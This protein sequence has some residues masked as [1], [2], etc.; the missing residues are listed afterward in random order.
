MGF[1]E[2]EPAI[3]SLAA[4]RAL[5][6]PLRGHSIR[7][8]LNSPRPV[9]KLLKITLD[10]RLC[11]VMSVNICFSRIRGGCYWVRPGGNISFPIAWQ[12]HKLSK[13]FP[14]CSLTCTM[15]K[16]NEPLTAFCWSEAVWGFTPQE[17]RK[18]CWVRQTLPQLP[19][20]HMEPVEFPGNTL[21]QQFVSHKVFTVWSE[22]LEQIV[23][24]IDK[25]NY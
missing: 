5:K 1:W 15:P 22:Q 3:P 25:I 12:T 21:C 6:L 9:L 11:Y 14:S 17:G 20:L 13:C 8:D 23:N 18:A 2:A 19:L 10:T 7:T 16:W 24:T 4:I